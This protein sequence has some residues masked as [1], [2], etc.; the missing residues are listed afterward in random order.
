MLVVY[1]EPETSIGL[2]TDHP[3]TDFGLQLARR[4]FVTL[5]IGTPGGDAQS[6]SRGALITVLGTAMR[7]D[8]IDALRKKSHER[9]ETRSQ[10]SVDE[11]A[12][13]KDH[14]RHLIVDTLTKTRGKIYGTDG[15]A[16]LLRMKPTTLSSRVHRMG[17][18]K[19]VAH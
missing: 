1:Y 3:Y 15:A 12:E 4:G 18:K 6:P 14:E 2:K 16:A 19:L 7:N 5:N 10:I 8:I 9:E 11:D 13:I 17:L